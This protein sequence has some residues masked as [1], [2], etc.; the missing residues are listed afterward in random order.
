MD[1]SVKSVDNGCKIKGGDNTAMSD[2]NNSSFENSLR[3]SSLVYLAF[4]SV[5]E[6]I[7]SPLNTHATSEKIG[8][9]ASKLKGYRTEYYI[10]HC[11]QED[12]PWR[13]I[14]DFRDKHPELRCG[15][16]TKLKFVSAKA[17]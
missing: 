10:T 11:N 15:I 3:E 12:V 14:Q 9:D 5:L 6:N 8:K 1:K 4:K 16:P 13:L 2:T 7:H 17:A